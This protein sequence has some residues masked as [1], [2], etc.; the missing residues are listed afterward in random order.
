MIIL[1]VKT[2]ETYP[3]ERNRK[4]RR[5]VFASLKHTIFVH[6]HCHVNFNLELASFTMFLALSKQIVFLQF[7]DKSSSLSSAFGIYPRN[8]LVPLSGKIWRLKFPF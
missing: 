5:N 8:N 3:T 2:D 4:S 1:Q 7:A 6:T